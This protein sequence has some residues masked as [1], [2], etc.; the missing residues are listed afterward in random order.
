MDDILYDNCCNSANSNILQGIAEIIGD[1]RTTVI[2]MGNCIFGDTR[3]IGIIKKKTTKLLEKS[4]QA[5][6][7]L[8]TRLNVILKYF[9][10][11]LNSLPIIIS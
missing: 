7:L 5:E 9:I 4:E 10:K 11:H 8:C 6:T 1:I 3:K 2:I